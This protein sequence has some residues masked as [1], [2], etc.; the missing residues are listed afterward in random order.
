MLFFAG[1]YAL[2]KAASTTKQPC[3]ILRQLV[4]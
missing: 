2:K 3:I 1:I 4:N